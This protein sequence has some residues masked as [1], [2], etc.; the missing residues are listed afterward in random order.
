[1]DPGWHTYWKNSGDSGIPTQIKWQLP[2][3]VTAGAIQWPLPKKLPPAEV[4]TYGYEGETM[5][6]MPLT[7]ASNLSTGPLTLSAQVSWLECKEQCVP[8][9][10]SVTAT[11]MVG[12]DTH[13]TTE[14]AA[15]E[16]WRQKIPQPAQ[17]WSM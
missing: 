11:L 13:P 17:E 10:T 8:G 6:L 15:I 2:P 1:M 3:G 7:L 16:A 12:N 14:A 4:T 9:A 5:L